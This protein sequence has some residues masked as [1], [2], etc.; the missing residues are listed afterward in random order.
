MRYECA[1]RACA[2][3]NAVFLGLTLAAATFA[4]C[5]GGS[6]TAT[7]PSADSSASLA[8]APPAETAVDTA[9]PA[10]PA[11]PS[12]RPTSVADCK[13]MLSD[14][15][16]DPPDAGVVLNNAM[17]AADAGASDRFRP[18]ADLIR[19]RREGFRCCFDLWSRKNPGLAGHAVLV[20]NLKGDGTLEN[21]SLDDPA[22][23]PEV[24]GCI[25][26]LAKSLTYPKSPSG[27]V[28]K[29]TYPF[30]FKPHR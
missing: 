1:M 26:D 30:D 6:P 9:A 3:A 15:T 11:A 25:L 13:E 4:A 20:I 28:T 18:V 22:P 5:G 12:K 21:A 16:N 29:F 17:T 14:I 2:T 24:G 10:A 7:Q 19:S 23:P 8:P 27:K